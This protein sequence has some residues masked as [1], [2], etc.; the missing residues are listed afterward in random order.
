VLV[1]KQWCH[2]MSRIIRIDGINTIAEIPKK[3][4]VAVYARVSTDAENQIASLEAQ[5]DYYLKLVARRPGWT[6]AGIYA[7]RGITGT[8]YIKREEFQRMIADCDA[9]KIDMI[10]TKS[11]SRFARNTV[12]TINVVRN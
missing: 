10:I 5:E 1:W 4:R 11:I 3:I 12:D 9:G 6:L 2:Q 7:D 8:S